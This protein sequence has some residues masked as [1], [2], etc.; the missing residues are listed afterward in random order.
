MLKKIPGTV[1]YVAY[2][3][4]PLIEVYLEFFYT[5]V[6]APFLQHKKRKKRKRW[7]KNSI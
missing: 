6:N 5:P 7:K 3:L 2:F 4:N 1:A